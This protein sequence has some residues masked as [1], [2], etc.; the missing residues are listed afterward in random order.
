VILEAGLRLGY[1]PASWRIFLTVTLRKPGKSDY[2]V[3]GAYRPIAEEEGLGKVV[4]SVLAEWLSK[5]AETNG[6]LSP[7]QFGGRPG[8]CTV[9]ALLTLT[10]KVKDAWRVGKVASALLMDISQ[11]FP[12][13]SYDHLIHRLQARQVPEQIVGILRSFL[14][15]RRTTLLFDDHR[16]APT[17]V[18][19][20]LWCESTKHHQSE[21]I[22]DAITD[23]PNRPQKKIIV[24]NLVNLLKFTLNPSFCCN[25]T[26]SHQ[27]RRH[28]RSGRARWFTNRIYPVCAYVG[29]V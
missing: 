25:K 12:S 3:P 6:L 18:P 7:N 29:G 21:T 20:G 27:C 26:K 22:I 17:A 5:F 24:E 16:S 23:V 14:S 19:N 11:A 2:T 9:D 4:E 10:Q 15:D 8:R 1:F 28:G 13:V